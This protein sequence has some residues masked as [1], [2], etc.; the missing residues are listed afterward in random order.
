[1]KRYT[2][3]D[4]SYYRPQRSCGKVIFLHQSV[5]HSIHRRGVWQPPGQTP[6]WADNPPPRADT[7]PLH[8]A[9]W[10]TVKKRAVRIL[11]ECIL[12][13]DLN[14]HERVHLIFLF[15]VE[16]AEVIK[17]DGTKVNYPVSSLFTVSLLSQFVD[18][19]SGA[20]NKFEVSYLMMFFQELAYRKEIVPV[21]EI[22][23]KVGIK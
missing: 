19:H 2:G 4:D 1:M 15:S 14:L 6:P 5:N 16:Y 3:H 21:A 17:A 18:L 10:D 20:L 8:S 11:L 23:K 9:C 22:N 12:V 7:P 13:I